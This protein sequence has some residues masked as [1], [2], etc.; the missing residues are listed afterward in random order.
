MSSR[1]VAIA[2]IVILIGIML[3]SSFIYMPQFEDPNITF[4]EAPLVKNK[5]QQLLPGED[6]RYAYLLNNTEINVTY[7]VMDGDGC[8]AIYLMESAELSG[9]C[10]DEWGVDPS[11]S[12]A[13]FTNPAILLFKPWML[14]L[15][16]TWRWNNSM[17]MSFDE[18]SQHIVDTDYR[19]MRTENYRGRMSFVVKINATTGPPEYQ[20][21]DMEKRVLL[22]VLGEDYEV[23]LVEGLPLN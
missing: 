15:H 19:V 1:T 12:N 5:E 4:K 10:I 20:W 17:Y 7:A 6:Y 14:A 11:G 22:R 13:T 18:T 16:E 9:V 8:T 2:T 23:R 21:I 3:F